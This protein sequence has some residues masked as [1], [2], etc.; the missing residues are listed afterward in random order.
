[1]GKQVQN[2][3]PLRHEPGPIDLARLIL[4][5]RQGV[6]YWRGQ[7][8][9]WRQSGLSQIAYCARH[10]VNIKS[11]RHWPIELPAPDYTWLTYLLRQ[12]P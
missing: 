1:M 10:D 5:K 4:R 2:G 11:F 9:A 3:C 8:E 6:D 12:L 7:V